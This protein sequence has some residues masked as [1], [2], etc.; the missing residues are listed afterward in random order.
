MPYNNGLR[1]YPKPDPDNAGVGFFTLND[2]IME[3]LTLALDG[4]PNSITINEHAQWGTMKDSR[5][6]S[7]ISWLKENK[8]S[9]RKEEII[10]GK[11]YVT[12]T[13][14]ILKI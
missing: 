14:K 2:Y 11:Q 3:K 13:Y 4:K 1:V 6:A 5:W 10:L 12:N 7:F 8:L 9:D